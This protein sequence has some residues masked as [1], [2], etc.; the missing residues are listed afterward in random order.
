MR[1]T[2]DP[3]AVKADDVESAAQGTA[4]LAARARDGDLAA[5]E[6]LYR[7]HGDRVMGVCVQMAGN[8]EVAEE[9]AQDA[10]VRAWQ[11]LHTFRGDSAFTTWLHRLTINLI[12]DRRRSDGRWRKRFESV[13]D[14]TELDRASA[15]EPSPGLRMDLER[16]VG[17][18]P[19]G[20]RTIFLLYDVEGF[21]HREIAQRLGV[22]EG[23]VKAQ[24]HRARKLLREVLA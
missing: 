12:L 5:F 20:A 16:A 21:R 2:S 24:L 17:T 22:A 8:R 14:Y 13:P 7:K 4:E 1:S 18:L 11:R 10:W 15:R 3:Q 23:T 19:E 6:A 9:W